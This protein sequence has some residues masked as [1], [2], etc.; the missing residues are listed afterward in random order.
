[1]PEINQVLGGEGDDGGDGNNH[2]KGR[3]QSRKERTKGQVELRGEDGVGEDRVLE[4]I[5]R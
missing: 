1:M 2:G 4:Y 5:F 3:G